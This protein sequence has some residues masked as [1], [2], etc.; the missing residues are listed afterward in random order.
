MLT[1]ESQKVER[2]RVAHFI[3]DYFINVGNLP[4]TPDS[5]PN[6]QTPLPSIPEMQPDHVMYALDELRELDVHRVI[7]SINISKSSGLENINSLVV[8]A[9][10]DVLTPEV[11]FIYNLSVRGALF[12]DSWKEALVIPIP[13]QGNLTKVQNYRPISLLPL[14]GKILEKLVHHQLSHY[15]ETNF[16]LT[17]E[18]HGF[19]KNH[20][21]IHSIEQVTSFMCKKG[22]AMLPTAAVFIDFR[23]AFDCVQHPVLLKKIKNLGLSGLVVDWIESYL[24]NRKQRVYAN[25][26]YSDY[27]DVTQGVPQ[28]SVLGPLFYIIY[29]NDIAQLVKHC[30]LALYADDTV[31]YTSNRNFEVS[32]LNLQRDINSLANWCETNGIQANTDR[33]KVMVFGSKHSLA[34]IPSFDIKFGDTPL[35]SVTSYKYLGLTLDAQ[36]NYNLHISRVIRFVSC[37]LKQFQRMRGFLNTRAAVMVYKGMIL[38]LLEYGDIFFS[39]ASLENRRKLQVLQNRGLRCALNKSSDYSSV[40]LHSEAHL[41]KLFRRREQHS[42]NFMYDLAQAPANLEGRP[43]LSIK[44]RSSKKRLLKVKR[45]RT[46]RFK[47]SLTYIGPLK[48]NSLPDRF[49]HT[50][51]KAAYK[52]MVGNWIDAKAAANLGA[53]PSRGQDF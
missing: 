33:T 28:G 1:T 6:Q 23:K 53:N 2:P 9:A 12:P 50:E 14:P 4:S 11:T 13:K 32:V 15:L 29:A 48:W 24:T 40:E 39:S 26:C 19:R 21:T 27:M 35:Q 5:T 7:K 31:L 37:K 38:P 46:E 25:D 16:L 47:R 45:P 30:K 10:F 22:D 20:S 52:A 34:Q 36:L 41:H 18:Q 43:Q 51:T 44:T 49:H 17:P 8:K 3:N 42:L